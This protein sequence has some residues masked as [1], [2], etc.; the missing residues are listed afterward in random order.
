M[1]TDVG[2]TVMGA[3]LGGALIPLRGLSAGRKRRTGDRNGSGPLLHSSGNGAGYMGTQEEDDA[4]EMATHFM[5]DQGFDPREVRA[6]VHDAQPGGHAGL[7]H[8]PWFHGDSAARERARSPPAGAAE[9]PAEGRNRVAQSKE[10][11]QSPTDPTFCRCGLCKRDNGILAMDYDLFAVA[12]GTWK[13][14]CTTAQRCI[15]AFLS[16]QAGATDGA[17]TRRTAGSLNHLTIALILDRTAA[18]FRQLTWN[19]PLR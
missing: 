1:I 15:R 4:D 19:M 7:S 14:R 5:L 3:G 6:P 2:D 17:D 9:R 16:G 8:G 18:Q 13:A 10:R 12:R 11:V